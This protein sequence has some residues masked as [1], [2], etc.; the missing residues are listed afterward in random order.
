MRSTRCEHCKDCLITSDQL[1]PIDLDASLDYSAATF[2]EHVNRGGLARP[3]DFTF[4][5]AVH[6]W[7]VFEEIRSRKDLLEQLLRASS[8]RV[9]FCKLMERVSCLQTYGHMPID[10]NICVAGHDLNLLIAQ[11]FFNCVAKNLVKDLTI[12]ANIHTDSSAGKRKR[13][14]MKLSSGGAQ[15]C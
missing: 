8:Q 15:A 11:R 13:K 6:C 10:G 7:R 14:C 12:Q 4:L 1:E 9:L 3:T 2:L 5:L